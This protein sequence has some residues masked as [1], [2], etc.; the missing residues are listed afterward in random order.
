MTFWPLPVIESEDIVSF[1]LWIFSKLIPGG[2]Y[3]Q[4]SNVATLPELGNLTKDRRE[5]GVNQLTE[6]ANL[7]KL[8]ELLQ[9]GEPR[10]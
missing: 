3:H 1:R 5:Q 7:K 9:A 6:F 4:T 10:Q 2:L 8:L